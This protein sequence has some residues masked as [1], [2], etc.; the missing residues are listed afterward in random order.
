VDRSGGGIDAN[1]LLIACLA[2]EAP[3]VAVGGAALRRERA[4]A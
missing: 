3:A 4:R 2:D 1:L